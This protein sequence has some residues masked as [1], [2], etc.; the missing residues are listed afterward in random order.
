MV[1]A[2]SDV[3]E[4]FQAFQGLLA[5]V[6]LVPAFDIWL[7]PPPGI[8][9]VTAVAIF[10]A[11]VLASA[12]GIGGSGLYVPIL[13]IFGNLSP[14]QAIPLAKALVFV[15]SLMA[16][17]ANLGKRDGA[18]CR[19]IDLPILKSI[20][21]PALV[22]TL[23]GVLTHVHTP[24]GIL[25]IL[26]SLALCYTSLKTFLHA[27]TTFANENAQARRPLLS[28]RSLRE[29]SERSKCARLREGLCTH[30][31]LNSALPSW[32][33][34]RP[35]HEALTE[36]AAVGS[37]ETT[38]GTPRVDH[39]AYISICRDVT[40]LVLVFVVVIAC[41]SVQTFF[42]DGSPL[43]AGFLGFGIFVALLVSVA[44]RSSCFRSEGEATHRVSFMVVSF[45][46]G[47]C[48][49][50][51]GISGGLIIAPFLIAMDIQ[52]ERAL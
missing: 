35:R 27:L 52:P 9:A 15:G 23:M 29:S 19:L 20:A 7:L 21:S 44:L 30:F 11:G 51:I 18:G 37:S 5:E 8:L 38:I 34:A 36:D 26:V 13:L 3:S 4:T 24:H 22:G 17:Y 28:L 42:P 46:A 12:S 33:D 39:F 31:R 1:S 25:V 45:V 32:R 43:Q 40:M 47:F 41:G 10:G 50:C 14:H 49:S 2:P 16:F 48:A 6:Q